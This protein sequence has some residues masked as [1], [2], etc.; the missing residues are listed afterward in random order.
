MLIQAHGHM[1]TAHC[2]KCK[3][4]GSMKTFFEHLEKQ[5]IYICSSCK[6]GYVKPDVVFFGEGLPKEYFEHINDVK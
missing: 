4:E 1:R 2:L 3:E 5:E 6:E